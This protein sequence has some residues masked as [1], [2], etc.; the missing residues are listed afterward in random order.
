MAVLS[1]LKS[2]PANTCRTLTHPLL[3]LFSSSTSTSS[4]STFLLLLLLLLTASSYREFS[5]RLYL[6]RALSNADYKPPGFMSIP[7]IG[8]RKKG[9]TPQR[10]SFTSSPFSPPSFLSRTGTPLD[11]RG[12]PINQVRAGGCKMNI[13]EH[14]RIFS[15]RIRVYNLVYT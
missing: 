11:Y 2:A 7:G 10:S 14:L 8:P 5:T 13:S 15:G 1:P 12:S 4:C 9:R 6:W 3:F